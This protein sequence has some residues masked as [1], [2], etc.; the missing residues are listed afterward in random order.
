MNPT[1][2]KL[3]TIL[4]EGIPLCSR[5]YEEIARRIGGI[6]EGEVIE[7]IRALKEERII[8]RMSGLFN[9]SR[10]GYTSVLC[11][12]KVPQESIEEMADL[13]ERFPGITHN[14]LREHEYNMWFTLISPG[15]QEMEQV[16]GQIRQSGLAQDILKLYPEKKYK[17]NANFKVGEEK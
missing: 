4:Q 12:M 16:L 8:R 1:D 9:S 11:G 3:L 14:Y 15:P 5:P 6:T 7:R 2:R 17:I 13:L 10:L